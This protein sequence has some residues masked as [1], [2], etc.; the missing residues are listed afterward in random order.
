[1]GNCLVNISHLETML[2]DE[3]EKIASTKLAKI[4]CMYNMYVPFIKLEVEGQCYLLPL[5]DVDQSID[6]KVKLIGHKEMTNLKKKTTNSITKSTMSFQNTHSP[7]HTF[8]TVYSSEMI[9]LVE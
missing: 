9:I 5:S 2:P 3:M 6:P 8:T 1:M 4:R 7:H